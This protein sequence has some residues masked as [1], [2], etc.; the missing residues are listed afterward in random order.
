MPALEG[1]RW[2]R[3]R[4]IVCEHEGNRAVR[5]GPWKLVSEHP[6]GW[7][8][9]DMEQDR[10][11]TTDLAKEHPD[12]VSELEQEWKEWAVRVKVH[13]YYLDAKQKH[14]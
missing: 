10:C 1:R 14:P 12:L 6:G 5:V 7:E 13:P 3:E 2:E 8:L 4:P 11:E 9:Y